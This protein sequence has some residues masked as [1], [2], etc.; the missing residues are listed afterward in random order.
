ML[1]YTDFNF[2]LPTVAAR[3]AQSFALSH[4]L[5]SAA[6]IIEE[7]ALAWEE[8]S[9]VGNKALVQFLQAS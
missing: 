1:E 6:S 5:H 9:Q 4:S 3:S 2:W 7:I 8:A